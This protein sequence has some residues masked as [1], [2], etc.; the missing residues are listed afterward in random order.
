M[1]NYNK[2]MN[3]KRYYELINQTEVN[4][5]LGNRFTKLRTDLLICV[6]MMHHKLHLLQDVPTAGAGKHIV[7]GSDDEEEEDG[8]DEEKQRTTSEVTTSK[9]TLFEDSRSEDET[10]A[11]EASANEKGTMKEKVSEEF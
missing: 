10:S 1:L 6:G 8:D 4:L 11:D 9:K 5:D 2:W 7:F 3:V